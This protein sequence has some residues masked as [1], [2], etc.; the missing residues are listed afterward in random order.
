[1]FDQPKRNLSAYNI[2]FSDARKDIKAETLNAQIKVNMGSENAVEAETAANSVFLRKVA[3]KWKNLDQEAKERYKL[4]AQ[5]ERE[6][7][8]VELAMWEREKA[9]A[10]QEN[11]T[12]RPP[13][14]RYKEHQAMDSCSGCSGLMN[15]V[16]PPCSHAQDS[17]GQIVAADGDI[18]I[19][20]TH[21]ANDIE[22]CCPSRSFD[23][24]ERPVNRY[25]L[26][27]EDYC[28]GIADV[29]MLHYNPRETEHR[30]HT[31][32]EES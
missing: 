24:P 9:A 16:K 8:K 25:A 22:L 3:M 2:F 18:C 10:E 26:E 21:F 30:M 20:A 28:Q 6:R 27:C 12:T 4:L 15:I 13:T 23:W 31:G 19:S 5:D 1:L 14:I 17:P 7:Y 11:L 29:S 32:A